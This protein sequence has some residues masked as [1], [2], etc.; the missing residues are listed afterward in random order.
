MVTRAVERV[1]RIATILANGIA[2]LGP[3]DEDEIEEMMR[4][5]TEL[6]DQDVDYLR[7]LVLIEGNLAKH[8]AEAGGRAHA[9]SRVRTASRCAAVGSGQAAR[10]G[11]TAPSPTDR[12]I[13]LSNA[14]LPD[15][16][17]A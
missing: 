10:S 3:L 5:A 8:A 17:S 2:D 1:K 4:V 9:A 11:S 15:R 16:G 12:D 13:P 7:E 14:R 6:T